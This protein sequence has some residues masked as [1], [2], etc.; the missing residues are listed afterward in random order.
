MGDPAFY[1]ARGDRCRAVRDLHARAS[2]LV[3]RLR[4][5][6]SLGGIACLG[7]AA[8]DRTVLTLP[9]LIVGA[10]LLAAFAALV[11]RHAR[12]E[13]QLEWQEALVRVNDQA[14]R[15]G[16]R[17]W[18]DLPGAEEHQAGNDHPYAGD[19]DLFGRAS[20]FQLLG[21]GATAPGR[22][23]LSAWLL[24]PALT[25]DVRQR[26]AAVAELAP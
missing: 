25:G 12:I 23:T 22:G 10:V 4:L 2:R 15:R 16:E 18:D 24:A 21:G 5:V 6:A 20:L 8:A 11:V 1:A 9:L 7:W 3:S 17:A 19:L 13:E 26:Q 14:R